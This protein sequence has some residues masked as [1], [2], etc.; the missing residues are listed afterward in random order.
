[1]CHVVH[2]ALTS[3]NI[4]FRITA[5]QHKKAFFVSRYTSFVLKWLP[6]QQKYGSCITDVS[7]Y[8]S[9][10]F[11]VRSQSRRGNILHCLSFNCEFSI[12]TSHNLFFLSFYKPPKQQ[13]FRFSVVFSL[14]TV[15]ILI[16]K[17]TYP[18]FKEL[19]NWLDFLQLNLM[20]RAADSSQ[21]CQESLPHG[22]ETIQ[23]FFPSIL[24]PSF[25]IIRPKLS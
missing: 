9:I 10:K 22:P 19:Q 17:F 24:S 4:F 2:V 5:F 3:I 11:Y 21:K 15:K 16:F 1:M 7:N 18:F 25:R 14:K 13:R 23:M 20:S 12:L 8:S 6:W